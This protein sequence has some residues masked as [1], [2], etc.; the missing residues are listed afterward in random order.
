MNFGGIQPL[1]GNG[2]VLRTSLGFMLRSAP[3]AFVGTSGNRGDVDTAAK[4]TTLF[5]VTG[6]VVVRLF[7]HVT[8]L[9][10][11]ASATL[12][13]GTALNTAGLIAQTTATD[14]D[15]NELWHDTSP[16]ASVELVTVAPEKVVGQNIIETVGTADITAGVIVYYLAWTPVSPTSLVVSN[17]P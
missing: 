8:T 5:T 1:D 14:I 9:L 15:A 10:T 16:D 11:G 7:A 13:V 3:G 17:Y 4:T 2:N 6:L 12:E